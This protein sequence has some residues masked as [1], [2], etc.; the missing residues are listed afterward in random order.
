M[1]REKNMI[2]SIDQYAQDLAE[3]MASQLDNELRRSKD[4]IL[5]SYTFKKHASGFSFTFAFKNGSMTRKERSG[6][7]KRRMSDIVER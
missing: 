7:M 1:E 3:E 5:T 6:E 4:A 2:F